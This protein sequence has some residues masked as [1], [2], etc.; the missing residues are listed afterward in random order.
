MT[1]QQVRKIMDIL[2]RIHTESQQYDVTF[3]ALIKPNPMTKD[4][5]QR[6]KDAHAKLLREFDRH[7][8]ANR[9]LSKEYQ[10]AIAGC[11]HTQ[12]NG[13]S[14]AVK[15]YLNQKE[16]RYCRADLSTHSVS[17]TPLEGK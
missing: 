10:D 12:P 4:Q 6:I 14:A 13:E 15:G 1:E 2:S 5:A 8:K 16:C 9:K 11:D 3:Y 7:V 17:G